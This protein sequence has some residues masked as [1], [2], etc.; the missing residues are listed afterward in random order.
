MVHKTREITETTITDVETDES[1]A[2]NGNRATL[3]GVP[4]THP[5]PERE[6]HLMSL[7]DE[8][9]PD[10]EETIHFLRDN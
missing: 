9:W 3:S 7:V 1:V 2:S 10:I 4:Y 6:K 8:T 5:D